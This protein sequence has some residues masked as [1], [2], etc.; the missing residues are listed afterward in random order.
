MVVTI[1]YI[2][3]SIFIFYFIV[4]NG[5]GFDPNNGESYA[6]LAIFCV[7]WPVTIP[8]ILFSVLYEKNRR[9]RNE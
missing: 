7:G 9:R 1:I 8:I 2:L 5:F 4:N 3:V 6:I